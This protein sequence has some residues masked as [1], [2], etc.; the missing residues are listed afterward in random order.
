MSG[1][2]YKPISGTTNP[3]VAPGLTGTPLLH[4]SDHRAPAGIDKLA[5][6]V[7]RPVIPIHLTRFP[8]N[9]ALINHAVINSSRSM[10]SLGSTTCFYPQILQK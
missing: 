10:L 6:V 9:H 8:F 7:V 3:Y 5:A 1:S 2:R 4:L